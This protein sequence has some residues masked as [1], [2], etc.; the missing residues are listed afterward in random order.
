MTT[1]WTKLNAYVDGEL[2]AEGAAE[3]ASAIARDPELAARVAT[4][5]KLKATAAAIPG[6]AV[7]PPPAFLNA[8]RTRRAPLVRRAAVA[9]SMLL[10]LAVAGIWLPWSRLADPIQ[11]V[12]S[13]DDLGM[14]LPRIV[15]GLRIA[16]RMRPPSS[17]TRLQ[18][19]AS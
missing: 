8:M 10:M 6:E 14:R 16:G 3:V 11:T 9:A 5:S 17:P 4:L 15:L 12:Q 2:D 7:S 1:D 19:I 13:D 18:V